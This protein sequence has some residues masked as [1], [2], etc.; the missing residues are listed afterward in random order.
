MNNKLLFFLLNIIALIALVFVIKKKATIY[1]VV[2]VEEFG[3]NVLQKYNYLNK[4]VLK[5]ALYD[6]VANKFNVYSVS[7]ATGI[8]FLDS[9]EFDPTEY[10][11]NTITELFEE[12][13]SLTIKEMGSMLQIK[14][15]NNVD[16]INALDFKVVDNK[17]IKDDNSCATENEQFPVTMDNYKRF[18]QLPNTFNNNLVH[19]RLYFKCINGTKKLFV[20]ENGTKFEN[21][22]CEDYLTISV[23]NAPYEKKVPV[24]E[25]SYIY[26][27]NGIAQTIKCHTGVD[28]TGVECNDLECTDIDG[29]MAAV[30]TDKYS[31]KFNFTPISRLVKCEK[32]KVVVDVNC[33]VETLSYYD[34]IVGKIVYPSHSINDQFLCTEITLKAL[35][36]IKI[37][38]VVNSYK[39]L[40][41]TVTVKF[42]KKNTHIYEQIIPPKG[43]Y[44]DFTK[45]LVYY[46]DGVAINNNKRILIFNQKVYTSQYRIEYFQFTIKKKFKSSIFISEKKDIFATVIG[47]VVLDITLRDELAS[48]DNLNDRLDQAFTCID[49]DFYHIPSL[50]YFFT[51]Y[52]DYKF[53]Y[54]NTHNIYGIEPEF[55]KSFKNVTDFIHGSESYLDEEDVKIFTNDT[56]SKIEKIINDLR[57]TYTK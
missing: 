21:G 20:C 36:N 37:P 46:N 31:H 51:E 50:F 10:Y 19:D 53:R 43:L 24:D 45:N 33:D 8:E 5:F 41:N 26:I 16:Y 55:T 11:Y 38:F 3:A 7:N 22:K 49:S 54:L 39:A 28:D 13:P 23:Q 17:I 56:I 18:L 40:S 25:S 29:T 30:H 2:S 15:G 52:N 42:S 48:S 57:V 44:P 32:G 12:R 34:D 9:F 4:P 35:G 1:K 27:K 6:Q 14:Y 47:G